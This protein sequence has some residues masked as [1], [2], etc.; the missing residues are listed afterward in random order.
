MHLQQIFTDAVDHNLLAVTAVQVGLV[1]Q[2]IAGQAEQVHHVLA[3][4]AKI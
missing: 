1:D 3:Q 4:L 2:T